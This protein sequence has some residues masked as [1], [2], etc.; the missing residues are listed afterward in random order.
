ML[1]NIEDIPQDASLIIISG[2]SK[3]IVTSEIQKLES[4]IKK[5]GKLLVMLDLGRVHNLVPFL[6]EYGFEIGDDIIIDKLSQVFGANYLTPVVTEYE[7][8]H[9]LTRDFNVA[10][11]FPIARSVDIAK[12]PSKGAYPFARTGTNSWAETDKKALEAGKAEYQEG[13]DTKG[14][15]TIGAVTAVETQIKDEAGKKNMQR[16]WFMAILILLIIQT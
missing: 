12:D 14:P 7:D 11:F 9:P 16:L 5:G 6:A 4:Y 1:L 3:D 15:V 2:P 10:T 8:K 13:K